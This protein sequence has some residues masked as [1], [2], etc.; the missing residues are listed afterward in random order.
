MGEGPW[1]ALWSGLAVPLSS[2]IQ[3]KRHKVQRGLGLLRLSAT[4]ICMEWSPLQGTNPSVQ[5][6]KEGWPPWSV[7]RVTLCV[8]DLL[9]PLAS[10]YLLLGTL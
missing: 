2:P 8:C 10:S 1:R 9:P 5:S 7:S 3:M 4:L 6:E